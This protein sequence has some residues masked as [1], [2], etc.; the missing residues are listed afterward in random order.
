LI[1]AII[2]RLIQP[3]AT[4][5][6]ALHCQLSPKVGQYTAQ[7]I[8]NGISGQLNDEIHCWQP[9]LVAPERLAND[10]LQPIASNGLSDVPLRNDHAQSGYAGVICC[11]KDSARTSTA[12]DRPFPERAIEFCAAGESVPAQIIAFGEGA[13]RQPVACDL[14]RG[15]H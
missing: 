9:V 6:S 3:I 5:V 2:A 15:G 4:G 14:W 8:V 7:I 1:K 11:A 10:P 13:F 12:A